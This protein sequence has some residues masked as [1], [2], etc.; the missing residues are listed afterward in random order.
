MSRNEKSSPNISKP[1]VQKSQVKI[2]LKRLH[3]HVSVAVFSRK[4]R[5][6]NRLKITLYKPLALF[7]DYI[8]NK[9]ERCFETCINCTFFR[10]H[11][12]IVGG[13]EPPTPIG[14]TPGDYMGRI[15]KCILTLFLQKF[16][17]SASFCS[18]RRLKNGCS[19]FRWNSVFLQSKFTAK[20]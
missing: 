9:V 3:F 7:L 13:G 17:K 14:L 6:K 2:K 16:S 18:I 4:I 10:C 1:P 20:F 19:V 5:S 8:S 12:L 15:H 11:V